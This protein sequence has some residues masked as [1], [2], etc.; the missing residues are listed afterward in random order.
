ME[1]VDVHQS[2]PSFENLASHLNPGMKVGVSVLEVKF[3]RR[4]KMSNDHT[5]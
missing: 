5:Q 1:S 4:T 3:V 2:P